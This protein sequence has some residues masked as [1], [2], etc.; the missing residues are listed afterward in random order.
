M[1]QR[2]L[3]ARLAELEISYE[4]ISHPAVFTVAEANA[5]EQ[6]LDGA[7]CK[8]LFLADRR[9]ERFFLVV[10]TADK[11]AN[12][13]AIS[14]LTGVPNLRFASAEQLQNILRLFP[15]SVTPLGIL[16]DQNN[17]VTVLI[18]R[19]LEHQPLQCHPNVNTKTMVLAYED[20]IKFIEQEQHSW[21][22]FDAQSQVL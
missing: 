14:K 22:L 1:I 10:L 17:L 2:D 11:K 18:D 6:Q 19:D 7:D 12:I 15:G 3:Y 16:H 5:L 9:G 13:K 8:N 4:E 20:L 21:M